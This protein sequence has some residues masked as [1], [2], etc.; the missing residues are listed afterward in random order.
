MVAKNITRVLILGAVCC[1]LYACHG[2]DNSD[3]VAYRAAL[4]T[5]SQCQTPNYLVSFVHPVTNVMRFTTSTDLANWSTP[6]DYGNG[7]R[8]DLGP[9]VSGDSEGPGNCSYVSIF[10]SGDA[11]SGIPFLH[12][13]TFL[14][15]SWDG[16]F[17]LGS[18]NTPPIPPKRFETEFIPTLTNADASLIAGFLVRDN[19]QNR[20]V[21]SHSFDGV[22]WTEPSAPAGGVFISNASP[23]LATG[24]SSMLNFVALSAATP[25]GGQLQLFWAA[26][27]VTPLTQTF[28]GG[29]QINSGPEQGV[30][31]AVTSENVYVFYTE[32]GDLGVKYKIGTLTSPNNGTI[33]GWSPTFDLGSLGVPSAFTDRKVTALYDHVRDIVAVVWKRPSIFDDP[34]PN[35]VIVAW[36]QGSNPWNSQVLFART[37]TAPNIAWGLH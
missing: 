31:L 26:D 19:G 35:R 33:S 34:D 25:Q 8:S 17:G 24:P 29:I 1:G 9:A 21:V 27:W 28:A 5:R 36:K 18:Q 15:A 2:V 30:R 22:T 13:S 10:S 4:S 32:P 37:Q 11:G 12:R 23:T 3:D 6:S 16:F 14:S 20:F 7:E